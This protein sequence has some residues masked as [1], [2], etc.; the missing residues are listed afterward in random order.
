MAV[1]LA[2]LCVQTNKPLVDRA[3][4]IVDALYEPWSERIADTSKGMLWRPIKKLYAKA[5]AARERQQNSSSA[6]KSLDNPMQYINNQELLPIDMFTNGYGTSNL[7]P[8]L[9][10]MSDQSTGTAQVLPLQQSHDLNGIYDGGDAG[11]SNMMDPAGLLDWDEFVKDAQMA[12]DSMQI[13]EEMNGST[14][15]TSFWH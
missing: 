15:W 5:R 10:F 1:V 3:W 12:A 8:D 11:F 2:E 6:G 13:D 9:D 14:N 4:F 7:L